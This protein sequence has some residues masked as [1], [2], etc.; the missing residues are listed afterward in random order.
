MGIVL[1]VVVTGGVD[2]VVLVVVVGAVD[3][4]VVVVGVDVVVGVAVDVVTGATVVVW[5]AG[6]WGRGCPAGT[7]RGA[8]VT[9]TVAVSAAGD[10]A[11]C[12]DVTGAVETAMLLEALAGAVSPSN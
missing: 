7:S 9:K 5:V 1:I 12:V 4:V 8:G 11:G 6:C 3:V 2:A 10:T